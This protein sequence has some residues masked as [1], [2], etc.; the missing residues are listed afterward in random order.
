MESIFVAVV[1]VS[2]Y[3]VFSFEELPHPKLYGPSRVH[4]INFG[5]KTPSKF[6]GDGAAPTAATLFGEGPEGCTTWS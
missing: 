1:F 6:F 4:S 3:E 5:R 2:Y